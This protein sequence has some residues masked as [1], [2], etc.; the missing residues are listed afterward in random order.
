MGSHWQ[1]ASDCPSF[2]T[3]F[4]NNV[5]DGLWNCRAYHP[6]TVNGFRGWPLRFPS[7]EARPEGCE[8]PPAQPGD[9]LPLQH[10]SLGTNTVV[11][12]SCP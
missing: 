4:K 6:E 8:T 1:G 3:R 12:D 11:D 9:T 5:I 2:Y 7:V 10:W